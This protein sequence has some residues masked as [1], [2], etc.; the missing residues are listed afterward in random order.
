MRKILEKR[1]TQVNSESEKQESSKDSK[2]SKDSRFSQTES[3]GEAPGIGDFSKFF[4]DAD[5]LKSLM[6][7]QAINASL[8][9]LWL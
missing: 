6:V 7:N 8:L 1:D 4:T 3:S 9:R 2:D 5:I